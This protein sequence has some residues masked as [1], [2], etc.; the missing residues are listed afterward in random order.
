MDARPLTRL[1][2]Q[3]ADR[4]SRR[5][6]VV[7]L[8]AVTLGA[9]GLVGLTQAAAAQNHHHNP[10]QNGQ[11]ACLNRCQGHHKNRCHQRCRR[12]R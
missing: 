4:A 1:T 10:Q 3:L 11:Q 5:T 12:T 2:D 8:G 9:A 7:R 6:I